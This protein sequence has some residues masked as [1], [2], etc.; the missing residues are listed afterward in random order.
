MERQLSFARLHVVVILF[1]FC[2]DT[3]DSD[4]ALN[5]IDMLCN[6]GGKPFADIE[7]EKC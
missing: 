1:S 2:C 3:V 6:I 4:T 5:A 7:S